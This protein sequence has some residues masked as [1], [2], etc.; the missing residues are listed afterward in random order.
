[1]GRVSK[2]R[3][4]RY[5]ESQQTTPDYSLEVENPP[6]DAKDPN[7]W[8][9]F[10]SQFDDSHVT[11]LTVVLDNEELVRALVQRRKLILQIE[12]LIKP[13]IRFDKVNLEGMIE[14]CFPVPLWKK[15]ILFASDAPTLVSK[16]RTLDDSIKEL[17]A[18]E[19]GVSSIFVT[20]ETE[21]AQHHAL[22]ALSIR[23][24]DLWRNNTN[25]MTDS[26]LFRRKH[27]LSVREPPEPSSVRWQDLDETPS[28]RN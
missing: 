22:S 3:E 1:M 4:V 24:L 14:N 21:Q 11:C 6:Q 7:E 8:R 16:I 17:A 13:G 2:R 12:Y 25:R 5:D 15:W 10:F 18:K 26:L 27:L 9:T 19:P 28:V 23:R 20:F